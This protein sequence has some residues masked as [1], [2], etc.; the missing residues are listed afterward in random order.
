LLVA[1]VDVVKALN[2]CPENTALPSLIEFPESCTNGTNSS[3]PSAH[4]D[5][6]I[7]FTELTFEGITNELETL[8][9]AK[10]SIAW[11]DVVALS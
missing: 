11:N 8:D 7:C 6:V 3:D 2:P 4:T 1:P 5:I 10:L 9:A